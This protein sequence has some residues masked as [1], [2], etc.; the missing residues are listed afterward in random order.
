MLA[1]TPLLRGV[2]GIFASPA[3]SRECCAVPCPLPRGSTENALRPTRS[4]WPYSGKFFG[5][6]TKKEPQ[7]VASVQY[8]MLTHV[9]EKIRDAVPG[10][11]ELPVYR[12]GPH[13]GPPLNRASASRRGRCSPTFWT[14]GAGCGLGRA[15][16]A[17]S[18]RPGRPGRA[19]RVA[20]TAPV[21]APQQGGPTSD[22]A[23]RTALY[24]HLQHTG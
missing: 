4:I 23:T 14:G 2:R 9:A 10:G 11:L 6:G 16:A 21:S 3:G 22:H 18:R 7:F 8:E 5:F 12:G 1:G 20:F 24:D 17:I 19:H 15:R 13:S